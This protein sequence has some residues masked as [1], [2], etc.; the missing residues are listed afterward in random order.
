M[1]KWLVRLVSLMIVLG[2]CIQMFVLKYRVI[3]REDELKA[4]HAQIMEDVRALHMLEAEWAVK[5]NPE[6]QYRFVLK[7]QGM[8][9]IGADQI[10]TAES[11]PIRPVPPPES[12][13]DWSDA[14]GEL[15]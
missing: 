12:R 8:A 3:D 13:P 11:L 7:Q 5:N 1:R 10:R 9:P 2:A 6:R 4:L 15:D 14:E